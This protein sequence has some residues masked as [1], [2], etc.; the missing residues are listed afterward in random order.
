LVKFQLKL[1]LTKGITK[2]IY[3][4]K[5]KQYNTD[6][7]IIEELLRIFMKQN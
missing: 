1:A 3:E 5:L 7:E 2:D 6:L 4:A